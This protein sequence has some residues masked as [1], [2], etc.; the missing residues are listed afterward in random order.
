MN[1]LAMAV[2]TAM[3]LTAG[4]GCATSSGGAQTSEEV[5]ADTF[6]I[7][8]DALR[9]RD[10][11]LA[12]AMFQLGRKIA[13]NAYRPAIRLDVAVT[14]RND[15]LWLLSHIERGI[16]SKKP[17]RNCASMNTPY[18]HLTKGAPEIFVQQDLWIWYQDCA[19]DRGE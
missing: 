11:K 6:Q 17:R 7:P 4:T 15:G 19:F 5:T 12:E 16:A 1:K 10:P 13:Y 14:K 3:L 18:I 2:M 8:E 9:A